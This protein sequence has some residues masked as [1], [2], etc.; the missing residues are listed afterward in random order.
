MK[1]F[2]GFTFL[3]CSLSFTGDVLPGGFVYVE[4]YI[5]S[6][7]IELRY[8]SKNNFMGR[9]VRGYE[10]RKCILS[11]EAALALKKVQEDLAK[12]KLGLKIY[13]A[14]RPQR[15]VNHFVEWARDLNDTVM[16]S[17]YYPNVPKSQLFEK[18]YIAARSSHS[19]GSTVDATLV[20]LED[21]S[22]VDMG[23]P[24]DYFSPVSW[25]THTASITETQYHNRMIL[26]KAMQA[27]GFLHLPTEW[28]HFTLDEEPYPDTYFD[29]V[30]E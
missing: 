16:K 1:K 7:Q 25:P 28:W 29:F 20:Y 13:D 6:L 22:E 10:A 15:A 24:Y 30:V 14:Y 5:P 27:N 26:Q 2:W 4:E 12:Q 11:R 8:T 19:R 21:G 17:S 23:T 18:G 9:P 3:L